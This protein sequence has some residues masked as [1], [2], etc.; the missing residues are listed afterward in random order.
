M[1]AE[2]VTIWTLDPASCTP[3]DLDRR[4]DRMR[5]ELIAAADR[6]LAA[7]GGPPRRRNRR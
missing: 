7:L 3:R 1:N 6:L 2:E 4:A 5:P